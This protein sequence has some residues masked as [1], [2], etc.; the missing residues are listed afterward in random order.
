MGARVV[1]LARGRESEAAVGKGCPYHSQFHRLKTVVPPSSS[2]ER[3][4]TLP[5]DE[6]RVDLI[7]R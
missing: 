6:R 7:I 1:L 4:D 2:P 5:A 3:C